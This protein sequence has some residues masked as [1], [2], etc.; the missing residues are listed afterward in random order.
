MHHDFQAGTGRRSVWPWIAH[1]GGLWARVQSVWSIPGRLG[2]PP[3]VPEIQFMLPVVVAVVRTLSKPD[4]MDMAMTVES[5]QPSPSA[6][7][8]IRVG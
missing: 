6:T 1:P 3:G 7:S 4:T 5:E 8:R 2:R